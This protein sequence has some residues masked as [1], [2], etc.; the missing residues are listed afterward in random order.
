MTRATLILVPLAGALAAALALLLPGPAAVAGG[1][2]VGALAG[3]VLWLRQRGRVTRAARSINA[4]LGRFDHEPVA[5]EGGEHWRHLAAVLNSLGA[6]HARR[7]RA[8]RAERRRG[9]EI[10][11]ALPFP[12]VVVGGDHHLVA[13]NGPAR[14]LFGIHGDPAGQTA[15]QA[16][17]STALAG[18]VAEARD[19]A[20]KVEVADAVAGRDLEAWASP[21]DGQ[22]LLV[23][24]DVTEQHRVAAM[25]R[26]FV[27]N[28]SH[29]LKSP[30][31]GIQALAE[32]LEATLHRD[33]DRAAGAVRRL[34]GE[35]RRLVHIVD[36]L[37]DLRRLEEPGEGDRTAV[38][39]AELVQQE[40][41]L[42]RSVAEEAAV[43]IELQA[44]AAAVVAGV[45][46]DLRLIVQNL[47]TNAVR[48]N[49]AGGR[50]EVALR[51]REDAYE[52]VVADTGVGIPQEDL[53]RVFERF[54]RVDVARSRET[55]GT[56][57]GL[58]IVRH[59]VRRHGGT[60]AVDS[61]LGEGSTF[62]VRLPIQ[63][64]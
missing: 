57:L 50:V 14:T 53:D 8:L 42:C 36:D 1:L 10:L 16:L 41:S 61:L 15:V 55:G 29:E 32:A 21:L 62:R 22:V 26:N 45:E 63:P 52:L 44:P 27:V 37:L 51:R 40:V 43:A 46:R 6:A 19:G 7:G 5:L 4:W 3:A 23:V 31:A 2:G 38:D 58:S 47:L 54:Y 30:V 39:L 20:R 11:E 17:G 35:A 49:V 48:Y 9:R 56:G 64:P 18:A 13:A 25:R 59:A 34:R 24:A 12:A 33:P 28:A 60:V